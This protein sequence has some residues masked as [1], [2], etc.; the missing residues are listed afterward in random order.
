MV[1]RAGTVSYPATYDTCMYARRGGLARMWPGLPAGIDF[2]AFAGLELEANLMTLC[3]GMI[4]GVSGNILL[5]IPLIG[6]VPP[7]LL[8]W[9]CHCCRFAF[10]SFRELQNCC[11]SC[12]VVGN[13]STE[14]YVQYT[15]VATSVRSDDVRGSICRDGGVPVKVVCDLLDAV[16]N[17]IC[18]P[19]EVI[20]PPLVRPPG[21]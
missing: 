4:L 16:L 21:R 13:Y 7:A 18:M 8:R 1:T 15:G 14:W 12:N 20:L 5:G 2:G 3:L 9:G 17:L 11:R 19:D 10:L 6:V